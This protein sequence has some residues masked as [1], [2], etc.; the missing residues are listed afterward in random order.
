MLC[1]PAQVG[2]HTGTQITL[3]LA[4]R[5][6][7]G[8]LDFDSPRGINSPN[9]VEEGVRAWTAQPPEKHKDTRE[10]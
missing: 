3:R 2:L 5:R 6:P 7:L 10:A 4:S 8:P 1:V 9:L